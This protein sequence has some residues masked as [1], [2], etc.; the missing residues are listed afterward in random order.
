MINKAKQEKSQLLELT[1]ELEIV[2]YEQTNETGTAF[3][4]SKIIIDIQG[5][6]T[7]CVILPPERTRLLLE[8]L[9]YK[10]LIED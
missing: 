6:K 7:S 4:E 1:G 2:M 5:K 8:L 10:E 9:N 3:G